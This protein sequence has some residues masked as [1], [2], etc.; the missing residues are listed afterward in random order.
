MFI[1]EDCF[2]EIYRIIEVHFYFLVI[3]FSD[4]HLDCIF[5]LSQNSLNYRKLSTTFFIYPIQSIMKIET[6]QNAQRKS[7]RK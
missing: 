5:K 6:A 3:N 7:F 4:N 2:V 1:N